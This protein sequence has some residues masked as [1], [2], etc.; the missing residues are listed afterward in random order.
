M[1]IDPALIARIS[2]TTT[3]TQTEVASLYENFKKLDV[4]RAREN[5]ITRKDLQAFLGVN[6][7]D[8][9][10]FLDAL[11]VQMDRDGNGGI[12]FAEFVYALAVFQ[13]KTRQAT[14]QD[15]LEMLFK[16]YDLDG[17]REIS[18]A[19]LTKVL[20]SGFEANGMK[21]GDDDVAQIVKSTF[22]K[23]QLTPRNTI[24]F[25]AFSKTK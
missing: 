25:A 17:D 11:F 10:Q 23:Y 1:S 9:S 21:V 2:E 19:D 6:A 20:K 7:A 22:A 5:F 14:P 15:K 16:V 8:G 4:T 18:E 12:D 24:D 13:N 3:Y